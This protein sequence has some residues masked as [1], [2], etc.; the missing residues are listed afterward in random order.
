MD[1]DSESFL[2]NPYPQ[3]LLALTRSNNYQKNGVQ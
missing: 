1:P 3:P 2:Q